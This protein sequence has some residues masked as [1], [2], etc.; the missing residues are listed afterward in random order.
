MGT[1]SRLERGPGIGPGMPRDGKIFRK[2][3]AHVLGAQPWGAD[4]CGSSTLLCS[5]RPPICPGSAMSGPWFPQAG[6][7]A[8]RSSPPVVSWEVLGLPLGPPG[9]S[10]THTE[11]ACWP[12]ACCA[13]CLP[14][15]DQLE[16]LLPSGDLG[17]VV[18]NE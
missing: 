4:R 12:E 3:D 10:G 6:V 18:G 1:P 7:C 5:L 15:L 8:G 16:P 14:Q 2:L 13:A 11:L 17:H 9:V